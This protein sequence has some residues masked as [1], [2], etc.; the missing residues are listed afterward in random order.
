MKRNLLKKG[1]IPLAL[2]LLSTS[3]ACAT[4]NVKEEAPTE[5]EESTSSIYPEKEDFKDVGKGDWY[6][7][8]VEKWHNIGVIN[9]FGDGNF[10]PDSPISREDA[11][12]ILVRYLESSKRRV[13]TQDISVLNKYS[14]EKEISEYARD[15]VNYLTLNDSIKGF[16]DGSLMPGGHI[17]RADSTIMLK[18]YAGD[19]ITQD[20]FIDKF[21]DVKYG[22]DGHYAASDIQDAIHIDIIKGR[23]ED[24]FYPDENI[25][26]AEFVKLLDNVSEKYEKSVEKLKEI[27]ENSIARDLDIKIE[28]EENDK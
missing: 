11:M 10:R 21:K 9:G 14:D 25:T 8:V 16:P 24:M 2:V 6:Y 19:W 1:L 5:K 27:K 18:S 26:R 12:T 15:A 13:P 22:E 20:I 7:D 17:T 4:Q 3:I 23:T 28:Y